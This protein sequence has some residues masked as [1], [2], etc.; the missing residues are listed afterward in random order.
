MELV[1]SGSPSGPL[2]LSDRDTGVLQQ[3]L[4]ELAPDGG[5]GEPVVEGRVE[6]PGPGRSDVRLRRALPRH[7]P[8][9]GDQRT[10][11]AITDEPVV[12]D[13]LR[14]VDAGQWSARHGS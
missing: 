7:R 4:T 5:D 9:P 10:D 11:R 6:Q 13:G 8:A 12:L 14:T 2:Q 3:A 1:N